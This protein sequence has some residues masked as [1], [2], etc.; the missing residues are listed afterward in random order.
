MTC[1]LRLKNIISGLVALVLLTAAVTI[2]VKYSFGAF[3]GGYELTGR[4][5]AAGQGLI[6][7]SDVKIRG[8]NIGEVTSIK[9]VDGEALVTM[10]INSG[11]NVATD[12]R[13]VV[14]P[15]TLFGEKFVDIE[16]G[17]READGPFY[18][19]GDEI[20]DTLGGFELERVLAEAYPILKA[21]DPA[22]LATII[23]TLADAADDEGE[24]I[25]RSIAN[26][27]RVLDV[28]AAHDADTRQ[29]LS[30]LAL[31]SGEL[32]DRADD[33]VGTAQDLNVALPPLNA[34]S[35]ELTTVL[36]EL[37]RLSGDVA[38]V[39]DNNRGF[40]TKS[41][42]E[43]GKTVQILADQRNDIV[44]LVM[45][46]RQYVQTLTEVIRIPAGD[47]TNLAA[48]KG[49]LAGDACQVFGC[50]PTADPTP[51]DAAAA[52]GPQPGASDGTTPPTLPPPPPI[53]GIDPPPITLPPIGGLNA[54][55]TAPSSGAQAIDELIRGPFF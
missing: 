23:T 49:I 45:G 33:V 43:G 32:A 53:P 11:E 29:F 42:T 5:E 22:E 39:L 25:N 24:A 7:G 28:Q 46:L 47:G 26:G 52:G 38:D 9:L 16:P 37:S 27:R 21:V 14:R 10:R 40:L 8:V 41:V 51:E 20:K 35:D 36:D 18:K 4:F 17:E 3:D 34:R 19:D 2:G 6:D 12:A 1:T 44:P 30:D 55:A 50:V 13:A 54:D 31:L 15:K 48:V